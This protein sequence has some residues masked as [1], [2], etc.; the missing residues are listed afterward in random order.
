MELGPRDIISRAIIT[1]FEAGRGYEGPYGNYVH[2][3]VRHL[4][5]RTIDEKLPFARELARNYIGIDPVTEAIPVRP[6][7]HYMMGVH[8]DADGA[9]P[10]RA[11]RGREC[12]NVGLNGANRLGSN[13]PPSASSSA[14]EPGARRPLRAGA[15]HPGGESGAA[16][17]RGRGAAGRAGV[18]PGPG[19]ERRERAVASASPPSGRPCRRRWSAGPA[20]SAPATACAPPWGSW[21]PCGSA[22]AA[23]AGRPQPALQH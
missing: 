22:R 9:T 17:R 11:L 19:R 5:E 6:V 2:L 3:D 15:T 1:E 16:A 10:G 4:G 14:P 8:T 23:A 21:A 13:S 20:S 18:S 7:V 12:A